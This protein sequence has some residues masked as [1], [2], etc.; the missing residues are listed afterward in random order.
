M[1]KTT[2]TD[3]VIND[4]L[5]GK[6]PQK[7]IVNIEVPYG[8]SKA[9][10]V[11]N[12]PEEGKYI[13]TQKF[14]PFLWMK[15][16]VVDILYNGDRRKIKKMAAMD[17]ITF[18]SLKTTDDNGF[19]PKRLK[20]GYKFMAI[21][22]SSDVS[23]GQLTNFFRKGGIDIY[24]E[25]HKHLF[26]R[27]PPVEQFMIQTGKRMFKGF[28]DYDDLHK[29]QFDLETEGL[30]PKVN[31]IFQIGVRDNRGTEAIIE[32]TGDSPAE[33]RESE[34]KA[35]KDFFRVID[36]L[37]PDVICAYNSENFDWPFIE[38][39][40]E[41]LGMSMENL[42][43]TLDPENE[44][45]KRRDST[46]KLGGN[47]ENYKQT[48]MWGY[49]IIDS[50]HAVRKAQAINSDIKKAGLK[51]ITEFSGVAKKN[52]V[53]VPGDKLNE[54]WSD[55]DNEY[56]L[57]D[58]NGDWFC[59]DKSIEEHIS[60]VVSGDYEKTSGAEI[61]RR[62]LIDDLWE[63]DVVDGIFNQATFLVSKILPTTFM[64][65]ATMGTASTWKLIMMAWS[66]ENGLAIPALE[67]K[68]A[69]VGG[70]SRLNETGYAVNVAKLDYAALYPNI[71]LT[72]DI[73]PDLDISGVMRGMLFY[74]VNQR[75]VY[76]FKK[77]DH[78]A[79]ASRIKDLLKVD[80]NNEELKK[81]LKEHSYLKSK[82][83]KKQLP[84][85]ILANSFFG[86]FGASYL[87]NWG[88][89]N[90]AEETTCRGRQYLR[91]MVRHFW[92]KYGF[93]PLVG[94]T[95]GYN[96][97]IPDSVNEISYTVK[98]T[99]RLTEKNKGKTL[100]GLEAVVADFNEEYMI[101]RMGLDIDDV[102]NSTIN[103]SRKNYANDIGGKI[104]LVGNT[105]KSKKLPIYIEEFLNEGIR[106]LLDGKGS[107][108]VELYY[109]KVDEI[110]NYQVPLMKIASKAKVNETVEQYHEYCKKKTKAGRLNSRKAYMELILAHD[111]KVDL[112][113]QLFYVNVG[114][115]KSH[116]DLKVTKNKKGEV[117]KVDLMC[118]LIPT[119]QLIKNPGLTTDE[120]N[121]AK[122][123]G[124]FNKRIKPLL[125]C[126]DDDVRKGLLVDTKVNKKTKEIELKPRKYFTDEQCKL[127]SGK[128]LK[129]GDQDTYEEI[130]TMTDAE[131][132]FWVS[133]NKL[134]NNMTPEEYKE[135]KAGYFKRMEEKRVSDLIKERE[136]ITLFCNHLSSDEIK[137]ISDKHELPKS[138]ASMVELST[139][140]GME[141]SLETIGLYSK[142][143]KGELLWP[144]T[145][146]LGFLNE[147][148]AREDFVKSLDEKPKDDVVLFEMWNEEKLARNFRLEPPK[149]QVPEIEWKAFYEFME[150]PED[151]P[152]L[153][154]ARGVVIE[155]I[156]PEP[157]ALD[158]E[159]Y[160][161]EVNVSETK[162][163]PDLMSRIIGNYLQ[164]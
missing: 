41:V 85:K 29:F 74:I 67:P 84:L 49:N 130:M 82:Y 147:A 154:E 57:N 50:Y 126:F 9:Y 107:E 133:V 117:E 101:G 92:E 10:L 137:A 34:R 94:D 155:D 27:I 5:E 139:I 20:D 12:D 104:K 148:L 136:N 152:E 13:M 51:Y 164:S 52:R 93:R 58:D 163:E 100:V 2:I 124:N 38:T 127:I 144:L 138:I 131:I 31:A 75:D 14:K 76:K 141:P 19:E 42:A 16:E 7:H 54:I 160:E 83:D 158:E 156:E 162:K 11:I 112:G 97:A 149:P 32:V 68:R 90:C 46:L 64:K 80:P 69:F 60:K 78:G 146:V 47:T 119:E 63:T 36:V 26:M 111:L 102:C 40:C 59:F 15:H 56:F 6:D 39:R 70:L 129:E 99:H 98:G 159:G 18:K 81:Q 143:Y 150:L 4:F 21:A 37:K 28:E 145:Y 79:E 30:D 118:K 77:N 62:Y 8:A 33:R 153:I 109:K 17:G 103:F 121:V 89:V 61:V 72:H 135:V 128:P 43:I 122:Y 23:Y 35:I 44:R 48:Y 22:K 116:G 106:L 71:E 96:F 151:L 73:F 157:H 45:I 55:K 86:S 161:E 24:S 113:D 140:D 125:V 114:S 91:L 132:R 1:S 105:I 110:F 88:D 66:Y 65:A 115:A 53:H 134:P 95:D 123:L 108:F 87:F 120:Y 142:N 3:E 25:K